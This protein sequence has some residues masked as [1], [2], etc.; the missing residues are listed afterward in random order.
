MTFQSQFFDVEIWKQ[1]EVVFGYKSNA[2]TDFL[3]K[4]LV[5]SNRGVHLDG[6]YASFKAES[7]SKISKIQYSNLLK[8]F[9]ESVKDTD[10][11]YLR[12]MY[13][14]PF[15]KTSSHI[16]FKISSL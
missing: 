14:L 3:M 12:S 13:S 16:L 10:V 15:P 1:Y 2:F 9:Y 8:E 5:N 6:L 4:K 7:H 11:F